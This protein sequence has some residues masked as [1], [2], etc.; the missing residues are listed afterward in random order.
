MRIR[1]CSQ[2]FGHLNGS[3]GSQIACVCYGS[4]RTA[5]RD[6]MSIA[7]RPMEIEFETAFDIRK[8]GMAI[9]FSPKRS[10]LEST[11]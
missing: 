2:D 8:A 4:L 3:T 6:A 1:V 9:D 7:K 5:E 10:C 11:F